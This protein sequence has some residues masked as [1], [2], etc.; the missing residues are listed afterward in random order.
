VISAND[1][2]PFGMEARSVSNSEYRYGF[3]GME[4]DIENGTGKYDFIARIYDVRLGMWT[5]IDPMA[6]DFPM[7][8]PYASFNNNPIYFIDR[9]GNQNLAALEWA[10]LN[11]SNKGI[12]FSTWF[13]EASAWTYQVGTV[14]T[15]TVCY[16]ACFMA[17]MNSG[18]NVVDYLKSTGF[19]N[20]YNAFRGRSTP[21][22]GLN[23]FKKGD[24]TDRSLVLDVSKGEK[25]DIIFMGEAGNM[26]GH[27]VL[28]GELPIL[29]TETDAKTKK[30]IETLTLKTLSTSSDSDPSG[31]YGEREFLFKKVNGK[32]YLNGD[33]DDYEFKGYGQLNEEYF[34]KL[35][36]ESVEG[37]VTDS[38]SKTIGT[39]D[40][41]STS[42]TST[43]ST[44]DST[45]TDSSTTT[46]TST[47]TIEE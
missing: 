47:T 10:R 35:A 24:G 46:N 42:T 11:M 18:S 32:W 45:V 22:G 8:S 3:G 38:T 33:V 29:G 23:W 15:V 12:Q 13:G 14:P 30:S 9:D 16:E 31:G 7:I 1:Y 28:L 36:T 39:T 41:T 44:T 37:T 40:S 21:N 2:Y 5:G 26:L 34:K 25:G 43:A 17:Y 20:K 27:A 4:Q 6:I 19:S